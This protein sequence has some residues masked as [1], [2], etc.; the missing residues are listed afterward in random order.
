MR[1]DGNVGVTFAV[2]SVGEAG[3]D[4][5]LSQ[6]GVIVDDLRPTHAVGNP[7]QNVANGDPQTAHTG[8]PAALA[9]LNSDDFAVVHKQRIGKTDGVRNEKVVKPPRPDLWSYKWE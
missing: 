9:R 6:I 1:A 5:L 4:I 2:G 8:T 7:A 3:P